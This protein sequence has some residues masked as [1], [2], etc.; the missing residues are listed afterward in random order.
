MFYTR[1][2]HCQLC[3]VE[4]IHFPLTPV[5]VIDTVLVT[6]QLEYWGCLTANYGP[7]STYFVFKQV[8]AIIPESQCLLK[9][10]RTHDKTGMKYGR[11]LAA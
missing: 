4:R 9:S 3:C 1:I 11:Y 7:G 5:L 8:Y 10:V 2:T 6:W